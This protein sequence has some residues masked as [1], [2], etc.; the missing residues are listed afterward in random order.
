MLASPWT[1]AGHSIG[2][3]VA[4]CR[5]SGPARL[6]FLNL[7][8][9][10]PHGNQAH[11]VCSKCCTVVLDAAPRRHDVRGFWPITCRSELAILERSRC[12]QNDALQGPVK[13][14]K[15]PA[16]TGV[17]AV[18]PLP[19][20]TGRPLTPETASLDHIRTGALRRRASGGKHQVLH[21]TSSAKTTIPRRVHPDSVAK[22]V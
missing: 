19:A 14:R 8:G 1:R 22:V 5:Q 9:D 16:A 18:N 11:S 10:L 20:L 3:N 7:K 17:P 2:A 6:R 21:R 12:Q 4:D 13:V 15:L